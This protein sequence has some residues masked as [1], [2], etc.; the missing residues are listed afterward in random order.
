MEEENKNVGA[1]DVII[2]NITPCLKDNTTGDIIET[3]VLRVKRKSFLSKFNKKNGWYTNW[4]ILVPENEVYALVIKGTVDIQGL[5]ALRHEKSMCATYITWMCTA[6]YN[7]PQITESPKYSGVGAHL[8]AI[9]GQESVKAGFAGAVYGFA[10]NQ[11]VLNHYVE[12]LGATPI[13][14]LHPYHFMIFEEEMMKLIETYDYEFSD[15]E[16]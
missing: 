7:N 2:D 3:E 13:Q 1:I 12:R 6:P 5:V 9:T 8:F 14:M 16:I 11:N 15:E 10:A 4:G